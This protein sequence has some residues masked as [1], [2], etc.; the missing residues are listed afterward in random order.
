MTVKEYLEITNG[1]EIVKFAYSDGNVFNE[2]P[3]IADLYKLSKKV[4]DSV[5]IIDGAKTQAIIRLK[6]DK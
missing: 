3:T 1:I 5:Y 6:E 2:L 4:I